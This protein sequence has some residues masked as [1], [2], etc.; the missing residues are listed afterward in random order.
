MRGFNPADTRATAGEHTVI[1][2]VL[3]QGGGITL[4]GNGKK[5][6]GQPLAEL[7]LDAAPIHG[8]LAI[9][10]GKVF[11]SLEDGRLLCLGGKGGV[12]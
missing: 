8:G 5:D 7:K 4:H 10:G 12:K 9:A 11:V 2:T 3:A 6:N 1:A